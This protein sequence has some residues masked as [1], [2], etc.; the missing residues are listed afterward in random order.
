M[1]DVGCCGR[2]S[3]TLNNYAYMSLDNRTS[4]DPR[5][6]RAFS[7]VEVEEEHVECEREAAGPLYLQAGSACVHTC[8]KIPSFPNSGGMGPVV[9]ST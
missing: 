8:P 9:D 2:A 4:E 7:K 1:Y 3:R 5:D 6:E